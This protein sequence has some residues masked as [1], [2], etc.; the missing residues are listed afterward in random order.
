MDGEG[1]NAALDASTAIAMQRPRSLHGVEVRDFDDDRPLVNTPASESTAEFKEAQLD[2]PIK[3][4]DPALRLVLAQVLGIPI[5]RR[6]DGEPH[7]ARPI[8]ASDLASLEHL[9]L[10]NRGIATLEGLENAINLRSLNLAHNLVADLSS[11]RNAAR[12]MAC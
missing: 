6:Y 7:L 3:I 2:R 1:V 11:M 10:S 9:D 4:A 8:L 12:L 5:T